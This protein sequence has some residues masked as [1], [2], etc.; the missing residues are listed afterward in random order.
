MN[1]VRVIWFK[2]M[3]DTLRDRRTLWAMILGPVLIM[4]AFVIL[5]QKLL[6]RQMETQREA[7][8]RVAVAGSQHAPELME[9]LRSQGSFEFVDAA[10]AASAVRDEQATVGVSIPAGFEAALAEERPATVVVM[11][12]QSKITSSLHTSRVEAAI[13][14]YSQATVARRLAARGVDVSLLRPFEVE[15]QNLASAEQMGGSFLAIMLPMF[16]MIWGVVGGMYTAI[17]VTAGE[18]ERLTLEPLLVTPAG[19]VQVVLGKLLAVTTTSLSALVLS[20][21]SML[22]AFVLAPPEFG[23]PGSEVAY[24]VP[25]GTALLM[26]LATVPIALMFGGLEMAVCIFA[27]SFKEAQNYI[28]P[29]QFV[30]ILPAM[31]VMFAPDLAPPVLAFAIPIFG[32]V[33]VLRDLL[34]GSAGALEF[35]VMLAASVL[36]AGLGIALAVMIFRQ[37]KVLFRT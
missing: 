8:I 10:D 32:P 34:V 12:D 22:I 15:W 3:L 23:V 2:E 24:S 33:M 25:L 29:L 26:L 13:Q 16:I 18:K 4:P 19:R 27:R 36:Y 17:D 9:Y 31:A 14:A 6:S 7:V 5:P 1:I 20:M 30:V 35:G 21:A 37:E 11:A 28:V